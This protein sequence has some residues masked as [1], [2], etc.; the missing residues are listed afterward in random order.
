M[1]ISKNVYSIDG[2]EILFPGHEIIPYI[3]KE[4]DHDLTLIDTC[5]TRELPKF[6]RKLHEL[7]FEMKDIRRIILTH[8]HSDHSQA[9]NE[10]KRIISASSGEVK[11]YAYWIDAAY[12]AHKPLYH[13]PPDLTI[14][15]KLFKHYGLGMEDI[16]K[17]FG[18]LD[19]EPTFVDNIL[20]DGDTIKSLKVVHTPGHTPGHISLYYEEERT[21]FGAD[22]LWNTDE[23]GLVIPPSHFTLDTET[24]AVSIKRVSRL[25]FDKLLVAHQSRP[26]LENANEIIEKVVDKMLTKF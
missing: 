17:K 22:I 12:L 23:S 2:L 6:E 18:R 24:A 8:L 16:I 21:L 4:S 10:V 3:M 9:A 20:G 1:K 25:N 26:M 14:Y 13:G 7:G 19:V 11:M 15:E 5:Y